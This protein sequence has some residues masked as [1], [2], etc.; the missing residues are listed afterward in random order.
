MNHHYKDTQ[1][2]ELSRE[3]LLQVLN[4]ISEP[5]FVKNRQHCWVVL[6]DAFCDFIGY[7]REELIGKSDYDFFPKAEADVFW[8]KDEFVFT[9]GVTNQS[10]EHFTDAAGVNHV[11]STKKFLFADESGNKFIVGTIQDIT[12]YQQIELELEKRV[13]KRTEEIAQTNQLLLQ[14]VV[15]HR[16]T[17]VALRQSEA[18]LQ[19]LAK[20]VPG[21]LYEFM[22]QPD[23][24]VSF[25][26]VSSGCYEIYELT[27][28]Q[29][30][31]D[32]HSMISRI[33]QDDR[34]N[35]QQS[36]AVSAQTLQP[37]E[38]E[39][40]IILSIG[41]VKWV[42]GL[43]RPEK[44]AN[45]AIVW[46]GLLLDISERK[47]A[48]KALKENERKYRQLVETSQDMI[49]SV[50]AQGCFTFLN[51]A[52]RHIYGYEPEEMINRSFKDFVAPE[53]AEKDEQMHLRLLAGESIFQHETIH[54][55]ADGKRIN[56][57]FNAIALQDET[58][59]IIGTTGTAS[60]IT[61]R[62]KAELDLR[63]SNALLKAQ[64]E[65]A[66]DAILIVDEN[67]EV[68]SYNR[69]FSEIWQIPLEIIEAGDDRQILA[70]AVEKT[71]NP[72]KFLAKV[73]YLYHHPELSS[74]DE[75]MLKDGRTLDRYSA[76]VRSPS[77]DYYGRIWS[78]RDISERKRVEAE[79]KASQQR[80]FLL[81][82]QTPVV[83]IEWDLNFDVKTWNPAAEK[84]FG[85]TKQEAI[86]RNFEF[87]VP[88]AAKTQVKQITD[89]LLSQ[90]GGSYSVNENI[91]K[92]DKII[93]CEWFNNSLISVD[94]EL[95][96]IAS[97]VVDITKRKQAEEEQQ[98]FVA[99]VEN[100]NDFIGIASMD[101]QV[102]YVNPAGLR[103]VGLSSLEEA[104]TKTIGDFHSP[105]DFGQFSQKIAPSMIERGF[106]QGE[107][108]YRHIYTGKITPADCNSFV[109]KHP[110]TG[111]P[112]CLVAVFRD[113][114]ERKQAETILRQSEAQLRVQTQELEKAL[115]EL[116]RTQ[117]QLVQSEKMS[118][119]G[120]L[121]A[122]VAH[123]INNPVNFI[124]GNLAHA[125]GYI[126]DLLQL[127][128]LYQQNYPQPMPEIAD[129]AK[130]IELDFL[131]LDLPQLLNSM[132]VG[133]DRIREIVLSLRTFSRLDEAQMKAVDI[134]QG[135]DSTLMILQ[136]RLKG[137]GE[138]EEIQVI[139][140][141]CDLPLVECY[142][143]QLN[144]VF[145]NI[146]ANA[147]DA[148][149]ESLVIDHLSLVN[150]F[151]QRTNPQIR[152]CTEVV[153]T[154]KVT[155]RIADNGLGMPEAVKQ[156]LFDPFFTTKPV[157]KGTGMGLSI[158]YQIVSEKHGGCLE[159]LSESGK[160][161]EFLITIPLI[162]QGEIS[163]LSRTNF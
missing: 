22:L 67:L 159:C 48:E 113:I 134:H 69:R 26:Y 34:Q 112:F 152:I 101:G 70:L 77:G 1:Q 83:I 25:P 81:I 37:W 109:V 58:G 129:F 65:A 72:E 76:P 155:I 130:L 49:W 84:I 18:K 108:H 158:S 145:M 137:N 29:I 96:G 8:E 150:S 16:Q 68:V 103:M 63:R 30:Q 119:L 89:Y 87:I 35:F 97:V 47:L 107:S 62:K 110:E 141:Y 92:D 94:G 151:E 126:Q 5:I 78:F 153:A 102:I 127:L 160:G 3:F 50:D 123:E 149:E 14:E 154:N 115:Y 156:R 100:I 136:S 125:S 53:Q 111:Q 157:G 59:N 44:Q 11:I 135:I 23:G 144:Q 36:V 121:V 85:Y 106:W 10:K 142:A 66:I 57:L 31:A 15:E 99:L 64:Q 13:E 71:A 98:K 6:N 9:T 146:L 40:Q 56:L 61:E 122:G 21:M 82:E 86:G 43:S 24:S 114:T 120:Q 2:Q 46:H 41:K 7:S 140:E 19:K 51:G 74:C 143:G 27:S 33:H 163:N 42:K 128:Q 91:T 161:T 75:V 39:G 116:Q 138:R 4:G 132:K 117:S 148:L 90:K 131:Q 28:E 105:E 95:I 12:D 162:Q 52:V 17:E 88:E 118:S 139:K 38:W 73:Q 147:I 45:G 79:L 54:L 20:N 124:F 80:L 55:G 60:N 32:A 133:A 104:K 93:I